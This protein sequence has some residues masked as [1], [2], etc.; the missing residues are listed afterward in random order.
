MLGADLATF[1]ESCKMA[2]E[3]RSE[4]SRLLYEQ[5]EREKA[6]ID[7]QKDSMLA[8][9]NKAKEADEARLAAVAAL[10][11]ERDARLEAAATAA[12]AASGDIR[13]QLDLASERQEAEVAQ[14]KAQLEAARK[15][16]EAIAMRARVEAEA[17]MAAKVSAIELDFQS[18]QQVCRS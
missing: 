15:E 16:L 18:K 11:A 4:L 14:M 9:R 3:D 1:I 13:R 17:E 2:D 6:L 5:T 8:L 7:G 12:E 10:Q